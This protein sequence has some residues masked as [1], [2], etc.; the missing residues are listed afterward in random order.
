MTDIQR[1]PIKDLYPPIST[2]IEEHQIESV[3]KEELE[4]KETLKKASLDEVFKEI[5]KKDCKIPHSEVINVVSKFLR[6]S[7][8]IKKI[9]SEYQ[10]EKKYT[11]STLCH[12]CANNLSYETI[13]SGKVL[14]KIGE[15]GDK[16]FFLLTGRL[17]VLKLQ[18]IQNVKMTYT[19]YLDYLIYLKEQKEDYIVNEVL[20]KNFKL[21]PLSSGEDLSRLINI[22]FMN[23]LRFLVGMNSF[24]GVEGLKAY[25]TQNKRTFEEFDIDE[26]RLRGL[27]YKK[28][29]GL[30]NSD[31]D[32]VNYI[33]KKCKPN[34]LDSVFFDQYQYLITDNEIKEFTCFVYE[35]F[36]YFGPGD[37]FGD[38]ALDSVER[39]RNATIRAEVDSVLASLTDQDYLKMI[40]SKRKQEKM[41]EVGFLYENFFFR[42]IN[43]HI[44]EKHYFHLFSPHEFSRGYTLYR[45]GEIP[46]DLIILKEGKIEVTI[47]CSVVDLHNLLKYL[48]EKLITTTT[49]QNVSTKIKQLISKEQVIELKSYISDP[50]LARMKTQ[51][52]VF[53]NE[54]NK[55]RTFDLCLLSGKLLLGV[56]E[57]FL[58]MPYISSAKIVTQKAT[59]FK[60]DVEKLKTLLIE[61]KLCFYPFVK[62]CANKIVSL[63]ERV[64]HLKRSCI[65]MAL[66]KVKKENEEGIRNTLPVSLSSNSLVNSCNVKQGNF[67]LPKIQSFNVNT[68]GNKES[69]RS[70]KS[71]RSYSKSPHNDKTEGTIQ[72]SSMKDDK[73]FINLKDKCISIDNLQK[74]I[75]KFQSSNLKQS[76]V[77]I[78]QSNMINKNSS[79]SSS[80]LPIFTNSDQTLISNDS[81]AAMLNSN[82]NRSNKNNQC[83]F[84]GDLNSSINYK[85]FKLSYV[86]LSGEHKETI[87]YKP[88][89]LT[90]RAIESIKY[91]SKLKPPKRKNLNYSSSTKNIESYQRLMFKQSEENEVMK[92]Q[93]QLIPEIVKDFYKVF[94]NHGYSALIKNNVNNTLLRKRNIHNQKKLGNSQSMKNLNIDSINF[95]NQKTSMSNSRMF[96]DK[97]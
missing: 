67:S 7:R 31:S 68:N 57:I 78:I 95:I 15:V 73:T 86:P 1:D 92:S 62:L 29:L 49:F 3:T 74:E 5:G 28:T 75:L 8:L 40:S 47:T 69:Q 4:K 19:Q 93:K 25:F 81:D 9:E 13:Q 88:K 37:F 34:V 26:K 89:M 70:K 80:L 27:W 60:Y 11:V 52:E 12:I 61:E 2:I 91:S 41:K 85:M 32:W 43:S 83:H 16:F 33:S 94:K 44:F 64:Q 39:K 48:Y 20:K 23:K 82:S 22:F 54:V 58:D 56:E 90:S 79:S 21:L 77:A 59:L 63:I 65:E 18:D 14:F 97:K 24:N 55:V 45:G 71:N 53:V 35:P 96:L 76:K 17:S 46:K 72:L 66:F 84:L 30:P 51:T 36:L 50:E 6:N 10:N 42:E 87:S 38:F